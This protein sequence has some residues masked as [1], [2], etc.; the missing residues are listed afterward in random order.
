MSDKNQADKN[1]ADKNRIDPSNPGEPPRRDRADRPDQARPAPDSE[2]I[3]MPDHS[4][5]NPTGGE[6]GK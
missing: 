4:G 1:Q 6:R 3:P 5:R 2:A